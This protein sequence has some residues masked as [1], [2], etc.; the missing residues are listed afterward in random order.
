MAKGLTPREEQITTLLM[1]GLTVNQIADEIGTGQQ[2]V[3]K[4]LHRVAI[5]FGVSTRA[6]LRKLLMEDSSG[7]TN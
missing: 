5:R 4:V 2:Y 3:N 7:S 1:S 6:E